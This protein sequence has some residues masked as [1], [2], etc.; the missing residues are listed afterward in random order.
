LYII[1]VSQSM[2]IPLIF[3]SNAGYTEVETL[4]EAIE[5]YT[6]LINKYPNSLDIKIFESSEVVMSNEIKDEAIKRKEKEY[7]LF[8]RLKEI[9]LSEISYVDIKD[10]N[11]KIY[12]V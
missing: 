4:P 11:E 8:M 5:V 9:G 10:L 2:D 1:K 6:D 7:D 12:S 3:R